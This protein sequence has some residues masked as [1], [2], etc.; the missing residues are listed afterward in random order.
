MMYI[1]IG[2]IVLLTILEVATVNLTSIWFVMSAILALIVSIFIDNFLIQFSVFIIAGIV[3]LIL[4]RPIVEKLFNSKK[5]R[6]NADRIIGKSGI[7]TEKITKNKPGEVKVYGNR[8]TAI[9]DKTIKENTIVKI[10]EIQGVKIVVE[11]EK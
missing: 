4:T 6:T 8:W 3:L 7:V 9:S 5:Q 11:E 1:W 10:L 2:I